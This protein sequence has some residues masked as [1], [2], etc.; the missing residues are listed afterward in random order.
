MSCR[1]ITSEMWEDCYSQSW[2]GL[3]V[4]EAFCHPAKVSRG[5]A[6]RIYLHMLEREWIHPHDIILDCFGGICGF[7]FHAVYY[8]LNFV[9]VELEPKFV[10]LGNENIALWRK[11][12][13]WLPGT[14]TLLQGDSTRLS[15]VL[16]EAG[17]LVSSPPFFGMNGNRPA[18]PSFYEHP[19]QKDAHVYANTITAGVSTYGSTPG[20]LGNLKAG[21]LGAVISSPPFEKSMLAKGGSNLAEDKA[22]QTGRN[23][24]SPSV[25]AWMNKDPFGET[26]GNIGS[27]VGPTFW[28]S[29]RLIVQQCHA[30]LKPGA[31]TAWVVKGYVKNKHLVDFPGQWQQ[32]CEA[33]G[34]ELVEE[35]HASLVKTRHIGVTLEGESVNKTTERK[36]FFRRLAEKNGSPHIDFETVLFM[37]KVGDGGSVDAI[38]SSPPFTDTVLHDGGKAGYLEEKRLFSEYGSTPGQLGSMKPG[39]LDDALESA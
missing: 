1:M 22:S 4:P 21:D 20:N 39:S 10:A 30:V 26:P 5:L 14:A 34:F 24:N 31:M 28:S 9:G 12:Y 15:E 18:D 7:G 2:K 8:G 29:A 23:P 17:A 37:R 36:S 25:Q 11:R 38:I 3:I 33:V 13:P 16:R 6:E 19:T 35:V 27:E 32:L